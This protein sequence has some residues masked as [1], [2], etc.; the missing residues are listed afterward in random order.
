[1]RD[2]VRDAIA[3]CFGPPSVALQQRI[4][5]DERALSDLLDRLTG[6]DGPSDL[7]AD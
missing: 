6:A 3:Q 1:M 2:L 7:L 4:A 5:A